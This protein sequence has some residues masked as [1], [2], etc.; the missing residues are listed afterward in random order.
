MSLSVKSNLFS[1]TRRNWGEKEAEVVFHLGRRIVG[2]SVCTS[3]ALLDILLEQCVHC[4]FMLFL[5]CVEIKSK[6]KHNE[7]IMLLR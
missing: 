1:G 6:G 7:E 4:D 5:L 3:S 2:I